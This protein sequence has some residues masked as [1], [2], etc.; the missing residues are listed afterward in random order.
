M[1]GLARARLA[2]IALAAGGCQGS[3]TASTVGQS[4]MLITADPSTFRGAAVC[5]TDFFSYRVTL[6]DVTYGVKIEGATTDLVSCT[7]PVSFSGA[8]PTPIVAGHCYIASIEGYDRSDVHLEAGKP[9]DSAGNPVAPA[10]SSSCGELVSAP[11]A[12][13]FNCQ[14]PDANPL[15]LPVQ[16]RDQAEVFLRGCT[17][18]SAGLVSDGSV[19]A[20]FPA[21]DAS[22]DSGPATDGAPDAG[23]DATPD[24][25]LGATPDAETDAT[26]DAALDAP[27]AFDSATAEASEGSTAVDDAPQETN[28]AAFGSDDATLDASTGDDS[29]SPGQDP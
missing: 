5:G 29:I 27:P 7:K 28:D 1:V 22:L 12:S 20:A 26:S 4:V 25:A 15:T 24:A 19:E 2:L 9:V 16:A 13:S 6:Y 3:T 11:D 18:F 10:W 21:P 14:E 8:G 23:V 17:P